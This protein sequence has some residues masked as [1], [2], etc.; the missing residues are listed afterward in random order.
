MLLK[1]RIVLRQGPHSLRTFTR[2]LPSLGTA[3]VFSHRFTCGFSFCVC[4]CVCVCACV[5]ACVRVFSAQTSMEI[6]KIYMVK[7]LP[8]VA[9]FTTA[10]S[11]LSLF[12][13]V[14]RYDQ[15]S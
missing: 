14:S 12:I 7:L 2:V 1:C 13:F 6:Y 3:N 8:K 4:V 10:I 9:V 5:R 11:N 15:V